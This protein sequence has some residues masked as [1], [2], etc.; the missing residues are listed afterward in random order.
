MKRK[1]LLILLSILLITAS[2]SIKVFR[3]YPTA[4]D[5]YTTTKVKGDVSLLIN[6]LLYKELNTKD[7]K[8]NKT[9]TLINDENN[10][11]SYIYVNTELINGI[12]LDLA[13]KIKQAI[14]A[15][16]YSYGIPIGN[17]SGTYLFSG[18][19]TQIDLKIV[20]TGATVYQIENE[21]VSGGINQ[22]LHRIKIKFN[23]DMVCMYPLHKSEFKLENEIIIAETLI[24]GKI[25]EIVFQR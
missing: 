12:A 5:A 20:P 24:I 25:P 13:A 10:S 6:E 2:I 21:L 8:Y 15:E 1:L 3:D 23:T 22:T 18:K 4:C 19:G 9:S 17:L 11:I 16:Q 7:Y 14:D